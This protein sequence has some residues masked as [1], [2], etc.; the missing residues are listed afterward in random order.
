MIYFATVEL[1]QTVHALGLGFTTTIN[2][3]IHAE[4]DRSAEEIARR[5]LAGK[6]LTVKRFAA[7]PALKQD[8][9]RYVF[10]EQIWS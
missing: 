3:Y 8:P 1:D 10:P 5:T 7:S 4:D 9:A 2:P 6:G